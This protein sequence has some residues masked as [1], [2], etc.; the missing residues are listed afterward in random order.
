MKIAFHLDPLAKLKAYKDTS[1][2]MMRAAQARGH[3]LFAIEP[4]NV[5][6]RNGVVQANPLQL[7]VNNDDNAWFDATAMPVTPLAEFDAIIERKDPPFD[8]EYV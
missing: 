5:F 1:V 2:A 4:G 6:S 8:M 7:N 3:T